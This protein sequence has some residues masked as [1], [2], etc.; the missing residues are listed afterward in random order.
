MKHVVSA[1]L[2]AALSGRSCR[3]LTGVQSSLS[4]HAFLHAAL[5]LASLSKSTVD[6]WS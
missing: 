1:C 2:L 6:N 3:R 5:C 4:G